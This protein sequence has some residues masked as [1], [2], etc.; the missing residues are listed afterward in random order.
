[1]GTERLVTRPTTYR[2]YTLRNGEQAFILVFPRKPKSED[3]WSVEVFIGDFLKFAIFQEEGSRLMSYDDAIHIADM[4]Y[5][6]IKM[7]GVFPLKKPIKGFDW[8]L[9]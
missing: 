5:F 6:G 7:E 2:K 1:M 8:I 4:L 3:V 9:K